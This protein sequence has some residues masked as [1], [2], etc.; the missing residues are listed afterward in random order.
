[1]RK[2]AMPRNDEQLVAGEKI[3]EDIGIGKN[4]AEH[5]RPSDDASAVH[6]LGAEHILASENGFSDQCASDAVCDRVHR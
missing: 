4:G 6:R 1:M 5:Q 3:P 2:A